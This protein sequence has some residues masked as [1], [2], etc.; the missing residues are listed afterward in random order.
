MKRR[1]CIICKSKELGRLTELGKLCPECFV[2]KV[3]KPKYIPNSQLYK[4]LKLKHE[5]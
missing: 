3:R 2:N 1:P 4:Y 5:M